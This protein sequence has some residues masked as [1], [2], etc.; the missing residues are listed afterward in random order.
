M[1]W[2]KFP[3]GGALVSG[4]LKEHIA[5]EDSEISKST[6][7][8]LKS[9]LSRDSLLVLSFTKSSADRVELFDLHR[10]C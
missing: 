3:V 7:L 1:P 10:L 2:K 6:E 4:V 8:G 5:S 9:D